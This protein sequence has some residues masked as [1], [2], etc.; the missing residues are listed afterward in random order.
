MRIRLAALLASVLLLAGCG[1]R[2]SLSLPSAPPGSGA[3]SE[4]GGADRP[5]SGEAGVPPAPQ[6]AQPPTVRLTVPEG[7]TLARIGMTL[8]EEGVCTAAEFIGAAQALDVSGYPLLAQRAEHS[9][10]AFALEGYLFPDTYEIY[11]SDTPEAIL[12][13]MLRRTEQMFTPELR[14]LAGQ[15]GYTADEILTLA[16]IIEKEAMG[17]PQ[18]AMIS[19]VLHNRLNEGMP[20]QCDVTYIYVEGAIKPFIEGGE[21]FA[22]YYDT[23][24]CP[25]LPAGAICNPGLDAIHAALG[26]AESDYFFFVTDA[27]ANYYYAGTYEEHLQNIEKAGLR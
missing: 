27:D 1:A 24:I 21:R 6:P 23:Y 8:E 3:S 20:L 22:E 18:M 15:S 10:R 11:T 7:Y 17:R 26:P 25:A 9:G 2:A 16:S 4:G 13:R 5:V 14:L 12:E 19:S